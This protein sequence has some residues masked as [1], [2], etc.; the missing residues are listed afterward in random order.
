ME[1]QAAALA[2]P[3][4]LLAALAAWGFSLALRDVSI[5]DTLWALMIAGAAWVYQFAAATEGTRVALV[6]TLASLWALRLSLHIARRNRGRG[7]DRRYRAMRARHAHFARESLYRV[8]GLQAVLAWVVALPLMA[9]L[10]SER[11]LGWLDLLG[12]GVWLFG[13]AF[14]TLADHQLARFTADPRNRDAVMTRGLWAWSRHPNY[15]GECLVW[16]GAWLMALSAGAAWTVISPLLMT[17]LLLRVSGVA[18][19]ERDIAGRRPGYRDYQA[20]TSAFVPLP[21]RRD[22]ADARASRL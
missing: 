22:T 16:W 1:W 14:E 7:E 3:M 18:L 12:A 4:L 8:F 10:A 13:I 2:L 21:P 6:L 17:V 15:F 11:P 19:L 9:T 5:V 20:R